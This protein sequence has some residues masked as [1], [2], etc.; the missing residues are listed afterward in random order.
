MTDKPDL[1]PGAPRANGTPEAV[2]NDNPAP[3]SQASAATT[4]APRPLSP[5][6]E[7]FLTHC[8]A[9]LETVIWGTIT[10]FQGFGP[11]GVAIAM[12]RVMGK[13]VGTMFHGTLSEILSVRRQCRE[14]F[15]AGLTNSPSPHLFTGPPNPPSQDPRKLI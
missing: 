1:P 2:R 14:A 5:I 8:Q 11:N 12:S 4:P 13:I 9:M 15:L 7:A 10:K 3:A 6:E